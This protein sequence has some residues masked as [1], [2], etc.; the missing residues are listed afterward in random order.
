MSNFFFFFFLE[1]HEEILQKEKET[2]AEAVNQA[3]L[4]ACRESG[5]V[6]VK[7]FLPDESEHF[8]FNWPTMQ[9]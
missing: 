3:K 2:R 1:E 6:V 7:M 8:V 9:G 4:T 5:F